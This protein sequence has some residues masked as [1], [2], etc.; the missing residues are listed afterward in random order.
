[1]SDGLHEKITRDD[2]VKLGS[3]RS[4]GI[5]FGVVFLG[6]GVWPLTSNQGIY[7]WLVGLSAV[8]FGLALFLPRVLHPLN[9]LWFKFG[10]KLGSVMTPIIMGVL[11]VTTFVPMG[12]FARYVVRKD[13]LRLKLEPES[14]SYWIKRTPPGPEPESMKFQF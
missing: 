10:M 7:W 6:V 9:L 5:I 1:M 12:L 3:E 11:F 4:F 14:D 13:F 2:D 8:F